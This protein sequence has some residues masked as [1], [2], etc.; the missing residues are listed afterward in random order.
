[1]NKEEILLKVKEIECRSKLPAFEKNYTEKDYAIKEL[2]KIIF[3]LLDNEVKLETII[4]T[5]KLMEYFK[6]SDNNEI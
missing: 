4:N 2:E 5:G 3:R 1:M 6:G